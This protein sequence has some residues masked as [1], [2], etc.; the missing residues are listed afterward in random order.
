MKIVFAV[1]AFV[2]S[3]CVA[4]NPNSIPHPSKQGQ[5]YTSPPALGPMPERSIAGIRS[6]AWAYA[7]TWADAATRV[8]DYGFYANELTFIGTITAVAAGIRKSSEGT[9]IGAI[10]AAGGPLLSSHYALTVQATN[11]DTAAKGM[12]CIFTAL[13]A[14]GDDTWRDWFD[15]S[16]GSFKADPG[17]D[18]RLQ[19]IQ[20]IP[21][22]ANKALHDVVWKLRTAQSAVQLVIPDA[23]SVRE[24]YGKLAEQNANSGSTVTKLRSIAPRDRAGTSGP[25]Q[26]AQLAMLG[27]VPEEIA[28]CL[29]TSGAK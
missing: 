9:L 2:L 29:A 14:V 28:A 11:Y 10:L 7:N 19:K 24:A 6:Q 23:S 18:A 8:R 4:L 1:I 17:S 12:D 13:N 15:E 22:I 3:G 5:T 25:Q 16:T 21:Q 26:E 27:K 20:E